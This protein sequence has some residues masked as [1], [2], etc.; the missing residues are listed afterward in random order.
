[1]NRR[2]LLRLLGVGGVA[3]A[4]TVLTAPGVAA[5]LLTGP[6]ASSTMQN[7]GVGMYT[8]PSVANQLS[9]FTCQPSLITCG[10]GTFG[11]S[12]QTGPFAMLMYSLNVLSYQANHATGTIT[13]SGRMRSIT[14]VAGQTIE[15]VEHDF[16][17]V[18]VDNKGLAP[19][20]W[21]INFVTPFWNQGNPLATASTEQPGKVRFGGNVL[22]DMGGVTVS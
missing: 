22:P 8:D 17:A 3:A 5:G 6:D 12:G 15:N 20:R 13:A 21:D 19:D 4:G 11:A 7:M 18:A 1:M 14:R 9:T 2:D 10:V 16:L